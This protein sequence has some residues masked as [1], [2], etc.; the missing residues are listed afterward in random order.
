[1]AAV[2]VKRSIASLSNENADV[3]DVMNENR[4]LDISLDGSVLS[5]TMNLNTIVLSPAVRNLSNQST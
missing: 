2:S 3:P 4:K 1:M 5:Y